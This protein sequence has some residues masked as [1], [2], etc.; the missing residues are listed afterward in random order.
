[1]SSGII[2]CTEHRVVLFLLILRNIGVLGKALSNQYYCVFSFLLWGFE[3]MGMKHN[4]EKVVSFYF[5][6]E[7]SNPPIKGKDYASI[8]M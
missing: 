4:H 8:S 2:M 3:K 7:I 1:M 6:S 5:V